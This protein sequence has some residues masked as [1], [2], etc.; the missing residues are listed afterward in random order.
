LNEVRMDIS[1]RH[2]DLGPLALALQYVPTVTVEIPAIPEDLDLV[3]GLLPK[4]EAMGVK[5]LNLHQLMAN[6]FNRS[7]LEARGYTEVRD[8]LYHDWFPIL[9]S[10]SAALEILNHAAVN[11]MR[12]GINYCSRIYKH[13]FQTPGFRRRYAPLCRSTNEVVTSTGYLRSMVSVPAPDS[14]ADKSPVDLLD[15]EGAPVKALYSAPFLGSEDDR[16]AMD[17]CEKHLGAWKA[18]VGKGRAA[19]FLLDNQ[20]AKLFFQLMFV[21]KKDIISV[22]DEVAELYDL[23]LEARDLMSTDLLEFHQR[24][25]TYEDTAGRMPKA[26]QE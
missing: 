24:F 9:E 10:E 22:R 16:E 18:C 23:G 14:E 26:N 15:P 20:T 19:E 3:K 2:Y 12:L 5:Y 7:A 11:D 25:E 21:E 8:E 6:D 4:L 13:S 17:N 1:A